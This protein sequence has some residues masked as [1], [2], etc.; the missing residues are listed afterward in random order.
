MHTQRC[1]TES[2][3]TCM[4]LWSYAPVLVPR[5]GVPT[6]DNSLP[7]DGHALPANVAKNV[8]AS[9]PLLNKPKKKKSFDFH[10]DLPSTQL[11]AITVTPE[12]GG[13]KFSRLRG[14]RAS[15]QT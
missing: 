3:S 15:R 5:Y 9:C 11:L 8:I 12:R 6:L 13:E 14:P 7:A 1:S 4:Y 2:K 10:T